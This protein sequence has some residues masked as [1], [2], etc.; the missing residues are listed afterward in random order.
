MNDDDKRNSLQLSLNK[1][2]SKNDETNNKIVF[3]SVDNINKEKE[4]EKAESE[5]KNINAM[6]ENNNNEILYEQ[7]NTEINNKEGKKSF[8]WLQFI[9]FKIRRKNPIISY[10]K[11][12]RTKVISEE[13]FIR[14][15]IDIYKLEKII[16]I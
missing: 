5:V 10:Y 7:K 1:Q 4:K 8:N 13:N 14:S 6:D 15:Q 16:K 9:W 2:N 12:Y 3:S 11:N